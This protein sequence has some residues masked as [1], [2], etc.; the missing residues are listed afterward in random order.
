[1]KLDGVPEVGVDELLG[2]TGAPIYVQLTEEGEAT[3]SE[4]GI[5]N[6]QALLPVPLHFIYNQSLK[7]KFNLQPG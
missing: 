4:V 3:V 6:V 7:H 2:P 5:A 1:M